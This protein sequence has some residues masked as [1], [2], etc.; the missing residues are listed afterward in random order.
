ML[1]FYKK[2]TDDVATK[3]FDIKLHCNNVLSGTANVENHVATSGVSWPAGVDERLLLTIVTTGRTLYL[4]MD[5]K[6]DVDDA[7]EKC[8]EWEANIKDLSR[9][10]KLGIS[11][12][13]LSYHAPTVGGRVS[14]W[15]SR[16]LSFKRSSSSSSSS[17]RRCVQFFIIFKKKQ[18]IA[19][20]TVACRKRELLL[21]CVHV[22]YII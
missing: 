7:A 5:T 2:H 15:M 12:E 16:S 14:R 10:L 13:S 8:Q 21:P 22:A 9:E 6:L 4:H 11:A 18:K 3:E 17:K 20:H 19:R 1:R